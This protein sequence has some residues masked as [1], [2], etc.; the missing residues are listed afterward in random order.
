MSEERNIGWVLQ[1][2]AFAATFGAVLFGYDTGVINGALPFMSQANQLNLSPAREGLV[3]GAVLF[4]AALGALACGRLADMWGRRKILLY[5]SI[6]F[7]FST[8]AC[9]V[10]PT[11][12]I[13]V[14]FR[15]I[16]GIAVGGASAIV[17]TYLA[18]MSPTNMR[19][20]Y[21]TQNEL[22]ICVGAAL[23]FL[24][25][26]ILAISLGHLDYIWRYM[27]AMGVIPAI[28]LLIGMYRSPES[29]RWL[30]R[31]G[32]IADGLKIL[33]TVRKTKEE[34]LKELEEIKL[35]IES[36]K[37]LKKATFRDLT[38]PWIRRVVLIATG[39]AIC[40]QLGAINSIIFYG[41]QILQNAGFGR[42][43][44]FIGNIA[45]GVI[46]VLAT[47]MA[48]YLLKKHGRRKLLMVGFIST[49]LC[50]FI[51]ATSTILFSEAAF[52]PYF[53]LFMTVLFVLCNQGFI[54]PL[55]WLL[56][57]ELLPLR[58]RGMGIG[59]AI[60]FQWMAEFA[61]GVMFPIMLD[62]IGFIG[63]FYIFSL[64]SAIAL[65]FVKLFVPETMGRSLEMI[66]ENFRAYGKNDKEKAEQYI[67]KV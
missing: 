33:T 4:G 7:I 9:S 49:M 22:M 38:I 48:I 61:I 6:I 64:I 41:T 39:V 11:F 60:F 54:G 16:L 44:A 10:S 18:E 1:K 42:D 66:E 29:P 26:A 24:I 21:V 34:A 3:V 17:P 65:I 67:E 56:V 37:H 36:E 20:R 47:F 25:N 53:I 58:V 32:R 57:S 19:G 45:N 63:T 12:E 5:L 8:L 43:A 31:Q 35:L 62:S 52:Y 23:A 46:S 50:H 15:F 55:T 51:I 40:N 27:L 2:I 59:V 13:I 28:C 14:P 30:I